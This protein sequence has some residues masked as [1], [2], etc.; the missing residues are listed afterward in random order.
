M[1]N[2]LV[3]KWLA[4]IY[5]NLPSFQILMIK[6]GVCKK[7]ASVDFGLFIVILICVT[8][9]SYTFHTGKEHAIFCNNNAHALL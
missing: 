1:T 4:C 5:C 3:R 8:L 9:R 6:N 2:L 7:I